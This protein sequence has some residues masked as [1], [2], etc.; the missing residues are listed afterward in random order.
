MPMMAKC[1]PGMM[2]NPPPPRVVPC[3]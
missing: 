3:P 1:R 2:C